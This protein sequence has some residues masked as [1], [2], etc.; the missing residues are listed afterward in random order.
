M[1]ITNLL[2]LAMHGDGAVVAYVGSR[3]VKEQLF[4]ATN[5]YN[6]CIVGQSETLLLDDVFNVAKGENK[7]EI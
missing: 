4:M 6:K 7:L 5:N 3:E 2:K 1:Q